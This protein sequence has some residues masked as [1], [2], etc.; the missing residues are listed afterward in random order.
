MIAEAPPAAPE[1]A[2]LERRVAALVLLATPD[3]LRA[4]LQARP[5]RVFLTGS[6]EYCPIACLYRDHGFTPVN[7]GTGVLVWGAGPDQIFGHQV[8]LPSWARSL[9]GWVDNYPG[10][11]ISSLQV[12]ACLDLCTGATHG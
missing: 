8:E 1:E 5:S 12:L 11:H 10:Q 4:Y 6:S 2:A 3:P 7:V 9:I